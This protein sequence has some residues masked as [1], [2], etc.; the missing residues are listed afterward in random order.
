MNRELKEHIT[1]W[2]NNKTDFVYHNYSTKKNTLFYE[3]IIKEPLIRLKNDKIWINF[4]TKNKNQIIK[5]FKTIKDIENIDDDIMLVYHLF[6]EKT[7][8][9]DY[10]KVY[11]DLHNMVVVYSDEKMYYMFKKLELDFKSYL[12]N[13]I[14]Y[15]KV[16]GVFDE[17]FDNEIYE[18]QDKEETSRKL[19]GKEYDDHFWWGNWGMNMGNNHNIFKIN[20]ENIR[21]ELLNFKRTI[22]IKSFLKSF[23]NE[24]ENENEEE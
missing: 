23:E 6:N 4:H 22:K 24:N 1:N 2:I 15:F 17:V 18:D 7:K 16:G 10:E 11:E 19:L 8:G 9:T 14:T 20:D 21:I 13:Y 5:L 3:K 12:I